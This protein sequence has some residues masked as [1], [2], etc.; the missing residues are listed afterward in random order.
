MLLWISLGKYVQEKS[1]ILFHT[2][3]LASDFLRIF[4]TLNN[5][6]L[7]SVVVPADQSAWMGTETRL[8]V[9]LLFRNPSHN[10]SC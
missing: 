4:N 10:C 7:T 2:Y 1:R 5:T 8:T 3:A 9:V 6:A